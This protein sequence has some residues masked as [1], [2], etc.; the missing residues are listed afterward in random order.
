MDRSYH[1]QV[2]KRR[3]VVALALAAAA[4]TPVRLPAAGPTTDEVLARAGI[5]VND[6]FKRFSSVVAEERFVQ[7]AAPLLVR[8]VP[9]RLPVRRELVSDYLLVKIPEDGYWHAFRDVLAVDDHPVRSP[10]DRLTRLFVQPSAEAVTKARQIDRE[11]AR[12]NLGDPVRTLNN[13]LLALGFLQPRYQQRFRFSLRRLDPEVG[14]DVWIVEYREEAR[15]TLLR[16]VPDGDLPARGRFWIH[17]P[18]GAILQTE[19]A[20]SNTDTIT[21]KFRSDQ[22]LDLPV[23]LE[24]RE[25]YWYK[26][27]HVVGAARYGRFRQF[28]VQTEERIK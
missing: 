19:L 1:T 6:Y 28:T 12:Y 16:R 20:L 9:P 21:T 10:S 5:Y 3:F 11:G 2:T 18:T 8:G 23:P 25:S 14:Q 22:Q 27:L 13:P 17:A 7:E 24:M 15:P 4:A 26:N